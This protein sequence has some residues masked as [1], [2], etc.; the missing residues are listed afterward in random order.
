MISDGDLSLRDDGSFVVNRRADILFI[1][2]YCASFPIEETAPSWRW[3]SDFVS[4]S[5]LE[6]R[7]SLSLPFA[8]SSEEPHR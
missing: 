5:E 1:A 3:R 6:Q 4:P 7:G 8:Q 2:H